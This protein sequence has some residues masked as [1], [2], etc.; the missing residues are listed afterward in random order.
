MLF[1]LQRRLPLKGKGPTTARASSTLCSDSSSENAGTPL[2]KYLSKLVPVRKP[3]PSSP[4]AL[5]IGAELVWL[6]LFALLHY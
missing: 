5:L 1:G 6:V 2:S 3:G 4:E